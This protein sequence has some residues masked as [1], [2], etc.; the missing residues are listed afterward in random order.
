MALMNELEGKSGSVDVK[1]SLSYSAQQP[2]VFSS[3][4]RQNIL[5]GR[6]YQAERYGK[7]LEAVAL[8]KDLEN[9]PHG[10]K[11]LVGEKGVTLS[12]GQKARIPLARALYADSDVVLLDDPL[13]AV[14]AEVGSFLYHG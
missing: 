9:L 14:D 11:S 8:L 7:V 10:D 1:G 2:W 4:I 3:T 6:E 12:G 13:S 5:F